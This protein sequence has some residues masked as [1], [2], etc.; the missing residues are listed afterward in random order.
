MKNYLKNYQSHI[1]NAILK[2]G[3]DNFSLTILEYCEPEK[4]VERE[5]FYL[6]SENPEYNILEKA[7]S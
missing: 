3:R 5:D 7:G 2:Y 1:F 4:C 6:L